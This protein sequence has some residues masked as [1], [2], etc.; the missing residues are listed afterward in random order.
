MRRLRIAS[1]ASSAASALLGHLELG[2]A[3]LGRRERALQRGARDRRA[4]AR[5]ASRGGARARRTARTRSR[6]TPASRPRRRGAAAS[7]AR[8]RPRPRRRPRRAAAARPGA[9]PQRSCSLAVVVGLDAALVAGDGLVLGAVVAHELAAAQRDERRHDADQRRGDLA[10]EAAAPAH[11]RRQ[12]RADDAPRR[13]RCRARTRGASRAG[14]GG[15]AAAPRTSRTCA[16]R[17]ARTGTRS[18]AWMR[19][20]GPLA[21]LDA[22]V[23]R[24]H[25]R[26]PGG[27]AEQRQPV[28]QGH[29]A[30]AELLVAHVVTDPIR[31]MQ[32]T[33]ERTAS[34][35]SR[36]SMRS[37]GAWIVSSSSGAVWRN[38]KKP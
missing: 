30:E 23:G 20:R 4:R 11:D 15:S 37:S 35:R 19:G 27:R 2:L 34:S 22:A 13:P 10:A 28:A 21:T 8:A 7:A 12:R 25:R 14:G 9:M 29:S 17:R 3:G 16:R 26:R 36:T 1:A 33:K 5:R 38:G 32:C 6:S 18:A 24:A 31:S